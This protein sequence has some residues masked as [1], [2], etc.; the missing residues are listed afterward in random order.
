MPLSIG[1][2][3]GP[4]EIVAPLGA[5]GM[6]E[7]YRARDTRLER[8][9]AVK[10]LPEHLSRDPDLKVRFER[11]ARAISSLNHPHICHLYD[12]GSQD[13]TDYLVMELL[14]GETLADR[15]QR[16]VVPLK[17]ALELA[18][19]IAEAL[20][21]AHKNGIVHRDLKPGNIMLTKAGAKLM[22]FGLSKPTPAVKAAASGSI[23]TMSK[24]LTGEGKIVGTYQYMSPE[25]IHGHNA[26]ARTD[27]FALG[28]VLYEMVTGKRAFQGKSQISVMSA[29]LEKEPEPL[30]ATRPLTPPALEHVIQ[31]SLAKD[32]EERWQ[33]AADLKAELKWVEQALTDKAPP[34]QATAVSNRLGWIAAA[35][36]AAGVVMMAVF[37]W[38]WTPRPIILQSELLPPEKTTFTL[39]QDDAAG[40]IIV[41]PDGSQVAFVAQSAEGSAQIYVRALSEGQAHGIPGTDGASYPFWS[42]DS[43]S[44]GFFAAAKL[45]RVTVAGGP[46]LDIC[47]VARPR[48]GSWA[49]DNTILFAPDVTNGIF[50]VA[51][52][53]GS[54]PVQVTTLSPDHSTHR[55]PVAMPDGKHFI[56]L[57]TNHSMPQAG[58][59]NGIYFASMDGKENHMV[60]AAESSALYAAGYLLWVQNGSL[61]AQHFDPEKGNLSGDPT[62][63]TGGVGT[64]GSTWKAGFDAN[65]KGI[66]VYQ[67][68]TGFGENEVSILNRDGKVLKSLSDTGVVR[69]IKLSPSGHKLAIVRRDVP[70]VWVIDTDNDTRVRLTFDPTSEG[71]AWSTDD[72]W[73]YYNLLGKPDVYRKLAD[74]SS[75]QEMAL[76]TQGEV[77]I[78]V[79]DVSPNGKYLLVSRKAGKI[80]YTLWLEPLAGHE[81]HRVLL[82]EP[83]GIYMGRFSPDGKWVL[84]QAIETGRWQLYATSVGGGGKHQ[85]TIDGGD[86]GSW[87]K[88]GKSIYYMGPNYAIF[89]M[90][91]AISGE[92]IQPTHPKLLMKAPPQSTTSFW[93]NSVAFAADGS[94]V[95]VNSYNG[96]NS[97]DRAVLMLNWTAALKK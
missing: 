43:K 73:L 31:R 67:P 81:Q 38:W 29:I 90:P 61:L 65:N 13:G 69:D 44:V 21:K 88:D 33:S 48:G 41:S 16:G 4:Y 24:P 78:H 52:A 72:R 75:H 17:Q 51:V 91:L 60:M 57:A 79:S 23:E 22:D 54:A 14:E 62:A 76:D 74:G 89:Q 3:L 7:V 35:I 55:W 93:A 50:K 58:A 12:V 94:K 19:Q 25:Q 40:P 46:V 39:N 85:L 87:S 96:R 86:Q 34:P 63:L 70:N 82:D 68:G 37:A 95:L 59:K 83:L 2:K 92:N 36:L 97:E 9:V 30:S 71:M 66:L 64:N 77:A 84:Y 15:L 53:P 47:S 18:A 80:P 20:E 28:A 42:A 5:G 45:R 26:D 27:I 49:A 6:G 1:T 56:Y 32:P 8:E 10:V 11:E